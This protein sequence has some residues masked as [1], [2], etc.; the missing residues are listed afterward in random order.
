[1]VMAGRD[2]GS[3]SNLLMGERIILTFWVGATWTIGYLAVPVLF[4]SLDDRA[5]AGRLA[6]NMF[7]IVYL[8]GLVCGSLLLV[9]AVLRQGKACA[10]LWRN[11][12]VALMIILIAVSLFVLQPAMA[13]MKIAAVLVEGSDQAADF[14]RLHGI[15]SLL[16]LLTSLL[17]LV[18]VIFDAAGKR[19][20]AFGSG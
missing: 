3:N 18:L 2:N 15:S 17:G 19:G 4:H 13:E 16:Y 5:L 6:G 14:G 20:A 10:R 8:L 1:M 12:A 7:H 11:W 9:S